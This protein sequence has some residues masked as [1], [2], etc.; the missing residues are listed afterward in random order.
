M[1]QLYFVVS[2]KK[3]ARRVQSKAKSCIMVFLSTYW[4][5]EAFQIYT[6]PHTQALKLFCL[7]TVQRILI[8]GAAF[9]TFAI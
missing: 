1:P 8:G 4:D 3:K 7:C 2:K 9:N 6:W 5:G